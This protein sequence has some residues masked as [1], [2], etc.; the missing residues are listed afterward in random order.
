MTT[1]SIDSVGMCAH[2]SKAGDWAFDY[3]LGVA[4]RRDVRLNV[5]YFFADP[6]DPSDSTGRDLRGE[7]R[8]RL[9]IERERE[10]RLYY[11]E[12][13]GD[14][15]DVGFRLCEDTEWRELHRC[16]VKREFQVLVLPCPRAGV[17]FGARPILDFVEDFACPVVVV[18]PD[19]PSQLYL[20][21]PARL[22]SGQL[23]LPRHLHRHPT[24]PGGLHG[25][26]S[27]RQVTARS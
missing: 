13:A 14:Y 2:Y 24:A 19:A 15:L 3:A 8:E 23:E 22:I 1:V 18:G 25:A 20:N 9:I 11:D 7:E 12:R 6:F 21:M 5:F 26:S 17:T 16:L 4:Q 27:A 10:L